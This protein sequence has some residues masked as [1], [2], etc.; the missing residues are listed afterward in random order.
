MAIPLH[1]YDVRDDEPI[2]VTTSTALTVYCPYV[3]GDMRLGVFAARSIKAGELVTRYVGKQVYCDR[4]CSTVKACPPNPVFTARV[5]GTDF[6]IDG[7][8]LAEAAKDAL[9]CGG[10]EVLSGVGCL[11]NSARG[12]P[13][14]TPNAT[15]VGKLVS[16][17]THDMVVARIDIVAT[18]DIAEDDEVFLNYVPEPND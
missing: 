18:R 12:L 8:I 16:L 15:F 9:R 13:H 10:P 5:S 7:T 1:V 11:I 14:I 6:G 17:K 3:P 4:T 2:Y